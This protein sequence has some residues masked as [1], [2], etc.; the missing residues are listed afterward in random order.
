[1]VVGEIPQAV[2][3]LVVGAGPGGY[4]AALRAAHSGRSVILVE[5]EGAAGLGGTCLRDACIPSKAL[6]Q[7]ANVLRRA[8]E[9]RGG[10]VRGELSFDMNVWQEW[11]ERLVLRLGRGVSSLLAAAGVRVV[12]GNLHFTRP[13]QAMVE[14]PDYPAS[15][16]EFRDV[17]IATGA[18]ALPLPGLPFD[19]ERVL[20][21]AQALRMACVPDRLL[22]IGAGRVGVELAETLAKL[23]AQ[24]ILC[25][26]AP[27]V[28]PGYDVVVGR[29]V[30]ARLRQLGV[31]VRLRTEAIVGGDGE[32]RLRR[33]GAE[34]TFSAGVVLVAVGRRPNTDELG[35]DRLGAVTDDSGYLVVSANQLVREHV[36]AIGD[37]TVGHAQA[38][39]ASAEALVAVASLGGGVALSPRVVPE[40][41]YG[42]PEVASAGVTPDRAVE[43]GLD[44]RLVQFP[45]SALGRAAVYSGAGGG[46]ARYVVRNGDD[47]LLGV[48]LVGPSASEL[49]GEA[50]L[51]IEMGAVLAD[52]TE[53]VPPH[54]TLV[55]AFRETAWLGAGQPIHIPLPV[56]TGITE[57]QRT[58]R[59]SAHG[60][61]S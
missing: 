3:L 12:A 15:Y 1:M 24:V 42:D 11:R 8:V 25:E 38:N 46:F 2:D 40:V 51:A 33:D 19:G 28:L 5:R 10:G 27:T 43:R 4:V 37:C 20:D 59:D 52:L 30:Q 39:R 9:M 61:E 34:E 7:A 13:S 16:F 18:R 48:Q 57:E 14:M 55:E 54:P 35:L 49:I 56:T 32:I 21:P 47:A 45:L 44:V 58:E 22:I 26:R 17:V 31:E 50:V 29:P 36:A 6:R 41:V 23:G 53:C 60:S